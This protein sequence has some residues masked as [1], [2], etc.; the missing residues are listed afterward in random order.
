VGYSPESLTVLL[1]IPLDSELS[2]PALDAIRMGEPVWIDSQAKLLESY[3]HLS[4]HV[5]ENRFY[6]IACVP[7]KVQGSLLASLAFTF[8]NASRVDVEQR[9]FLMLVARYASQ[10]MER[11][12]LLELERTSRNRA[13]LLYSL[14][15]SMNAADNIDTVFGAALASVQRALGAERSSILIADGD[16]VMRFRAWRGL[17]DDYRRAVDSH[18]PWARDVVDPQPI[19]VADV[20]VDPAL[21]GYRELFASEGVAALGFFPLVANG[22]LIGKFMVYYGSPRTISRAELGMAGAIADHVAAAVTR[23]AAAAELRDTVHFNELFAGILGH[24]LRNPLS[25]IMAAAQLVSLRAT[26]PRLATP[27]ERIIRSG[28]RMSRMIDQLLDFTRVRVGTGIP[29]RKRHLDLATI[30][31]QVFEEHESSH[32]G[33]PLTIE[34]RGDTS[35]EWDADRLYQV[36]SNLVGNA[37]RHGNAS[38]GGSITADGTDSD[39]VR[40][41]VHN[42]GVVPAALVPR[43]FDP[44]S[45]GGGDSWNSTGQGLGLGL[46]ITKELVTAHG[47]RI[48]VQSSETSGTMVTV[49]LP[50]VTVRVT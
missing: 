12:R 4:Q 2:N 45:G 41:R 36:F 47:G 29:L 50:R 27:V 48:E 1:S 49:T 6:S 25:A 43:L 22:R 44:M 23:F 16:G 32:P 35:G 9:D 7:L 11:L 39:A 42:M 21:Q 19:F 3:P 8:E 10:A 15:A 34:T 24:D 28:E 20:T 31:G 37:V 5:S 26:D 38:D 40:V 17:S 46:Y 13:E 14:A 33:W 18:S 30:L